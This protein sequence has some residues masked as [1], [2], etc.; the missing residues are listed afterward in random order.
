MQDW[1]QIKKSIDGSFCCGTAEANPASI[2][3]DVGLI[4]GLTQWVGDP[5]LPRAVV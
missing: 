1:F 5:A 4:P 2:R 3:E